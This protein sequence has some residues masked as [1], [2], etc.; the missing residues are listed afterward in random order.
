MREFTSQL[1]PVKLSLVASG[2]Y[3]PL[4]PVVYSPARNVG[5]WCGILP[6]TV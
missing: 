3:R 1:G 6:A 4:A 5:A 2:G